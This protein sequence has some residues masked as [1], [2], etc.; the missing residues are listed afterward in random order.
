MPAKASIQYSLNLSHRHYPL[1]STRLDRPLS[2]AMTIGDSGA[3]TQC[4]PGPVLNFASRHASMPA[5]TGGSALPFMDANGISIH[6]ELAGSGP[7]VVLLHEMGGTL[8]SWDSIFPA[9]SG[10]YRTL[11]YDQRGA[12][13]TEKVRNVTTEILLADLEAVLQQSGLPPPLPFRHRRGGHHAGAALHGEV[14]RPDRKLHVL[15]SFHR[16][17]SE[18]GR[19]AAGARGPGR[20]RRPARR[21]SDHARQL[22]AVRI[23]AIR[24]RT[25]PIAGATWRT[26]RCALRRSTGR[27]RSPT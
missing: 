21:H 20:A 13:L 26:I 4:S 27:S 9:L 11:R 16:R 8:A 12:G 18:P 23:S 15:Q 2:R 7:S 10:R 24:R 3:P 19:D 22:L 1:T 14:S 5:N 17:R 6:Y 25:P